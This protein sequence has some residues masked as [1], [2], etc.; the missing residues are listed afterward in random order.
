MYYLIMK[1]NLKY[2]FFLLFIAFQTQGTSLLYAQGEGYSQYKLF[3]EEKIENYF[4][5]ISLSPKNPVVG[6][7]IFSINVVDNTTKEAVEN[8]K[9]QVYATPLFNDNKKKSPALS[10]AGMKGYYQAILRLEKQG[11]WVMDFEIDDGKKVFMVSEQIEIF[12]R[13]RT[14]NSNSFSYGFIVMQLV[15]VFG[16]GFVFIN[17]RKK[18][19]ELLN[20]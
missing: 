5:S 3:H 20:K 14:L 17:A 16:I 11:N 10:S 6:Q 13:N 1:K 4:V 12:E 2:L 15:F 19:K 7:Q 8:L 18:R 9:I